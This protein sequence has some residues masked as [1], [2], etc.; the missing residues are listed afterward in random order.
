[1]LLKSDYEGWLV[2]KAKRLNGVN[3]NGVIYI[4]IYIYIYI[5]S[6]VVL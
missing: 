4:Y 5:L 2:F 3:N 6:L 1:M